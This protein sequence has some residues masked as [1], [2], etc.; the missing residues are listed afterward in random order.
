M[1]HSHISLLY[2]IVNCFSNMVAQFQAFS[3]LS[4]SSTWRCR[5]PQNSSQPSRLRRRG[6]G[7]LLF[8]M[9]IDRLVRPPHHTNSLSSIS[10]RSA[11]FS[12]VASL[13]PGLWLTLVFDFSQRAPPCCLRGTE[14][15]SLVSLSSAS[16]LFPLLRASTRPH[17]A[18]LCVPCPPP[19]HLF[20]FASSMAFSHCASISAS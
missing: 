19:H 16:R 13:D 18:L 17:R 9:A 2:R 15:A 14:P 10:S 4:S 11:P 6:I 7:H 1:P 20:A 5:T 8:F 12:P 3:P